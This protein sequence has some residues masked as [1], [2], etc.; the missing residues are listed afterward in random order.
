MANALYFSGTTRLFSDFNASMPNDQFR[1][2]FPGVKALSYDGYQKRMARDENGRLMPV[3]RV[4][5]RKVAPS[6]HKCDARCLHAKGNQCE[7]ECGGQ[8]H[9]AGA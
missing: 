3:T 8:F 6:N 9:G 7:C 5:F 2:A 4:V 1:A